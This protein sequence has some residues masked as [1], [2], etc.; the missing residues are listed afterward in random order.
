MLG[1]LQVV[2]DD[3]AEI[4]LATRQRRLLAALIVGGGEVCSRDS[5]VEAVWNGAPPRSSTKVLQ[6]YVSRLRTKLEPAGVTIR[7]VRGFGYLLE[8]PREG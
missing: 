1:P 2:C 7:T 8:A 5:L 3:G 6:V 4:A